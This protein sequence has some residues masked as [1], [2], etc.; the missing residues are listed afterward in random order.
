[1]VDPERGCTVAKAAKPA[2]VRHHAE[3]P[4]VSRSE[5]DVYRFKLEGKLI[6]TVSCSGPGLLPCAG[7]GRLL[8]FVAC[9]GQS[10]SDCGRSIMEVM[11]TIL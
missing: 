2:V 7:R 4:R 9:R 10:L 5:L 1:M 3:K 8:G 6:A 11:Q